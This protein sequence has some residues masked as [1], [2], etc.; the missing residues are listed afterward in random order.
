VTLRFSDHFGLGKSQA[1][2]DFVDVDLH[3]DIPLFVDPYAISL[4]DTEW[5]IECNNLI[6]DFFELVVQSIRDG[7][8]VRAR[9]LLSN[10]REPNDTRL[11]LSTGRS[12][13][14][15][16]GGEQ[17]GQIFDRLKDSKAVLTGNLT[18]LAD[19]ELV[20]RGIGRDKIS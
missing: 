16:I 7:N 17:S 18:D 12:R 1:Q 3:T 11:G 9:S 15:G 14:N 6:I 8:E 19:T 2:L 20:I 5:F 4:E 13:G 10:L